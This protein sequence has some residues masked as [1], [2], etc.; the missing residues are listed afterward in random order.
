[1]L[2]LTQQPVVLAL[3]ACPDLSQQ[4]A[5]YWLPNPDAGTWL[6]SAPLTLPKWNL[7]PLPHSVDQSAIVCSP[8]CG[9]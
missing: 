7:V 3:P 8:V 5:P 6:P 2:P 4:R 9:P 1:M